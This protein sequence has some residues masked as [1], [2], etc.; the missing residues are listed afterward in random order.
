MLVAG[1]VVTLGA[2]AGA[3]TTGTPPPQAFILVDA[4]T[5]AVITARNMHEALPPAS[6]VK[7]MTALV[8][9][10]RLPADATIPVSA[11]AANREAMKI[12]MQAGTRWPLDETMASMMMVS[13]NDSAYAIAE[14]RRR[15][16]PR[17]RRD[18]PT[19][20]RAATACATARSATR[21]ASTTPPSYEGGPKVSAYDLAI[22]TRNALTVPAIAQWAATTQHYEFTDPTGLH[23]HARQPQQVPA[24]QRVR[25]R[26][27]RTASRPGSPKPRSTRSSRPRSATAASCIAVIL[28]S[29]DSGYT[30]A[31][32]L[33]DQCWQ[34]PAVK[35]MSTRLPPVA[36]S[37]YATR[38]ADQTASRPLA[39]GDTNVRRSPTT[40][41]PAA[42]DR[43]PRRR[44]PTRPTPAAPRRDHRDRR[45]R[46]DDASTAPGCSRA[47]PARAGGSC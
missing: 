23:A 21:P 43:R 26:G 13:A 30:W 24:R 2:P 31:A 3:D 11:N 44:A 18:S 42:H 15:Q 17:L 28:G 8:A 7:I 33:L 41:V 35:T 1:L 37:P 34:K 46:A 16:H 4:G 40:T 45:D 10:E 5:G 14:T 38:A 19:R 20:P 29:V 47:V 25:L 6:T 12:G 9:V 32:S 36:V 39:V 27:R 22:A